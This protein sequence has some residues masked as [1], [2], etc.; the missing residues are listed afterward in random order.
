MGAHRY[1]LRYKTLGTTNWSSLGPIYHPANNTV[2][3]LLQQNTSY[4]W[5]IKTYH[6][7]STI[8]ASMWSLSDTFTTTSFV[9]ATFNPIISNT[10][11]TLEC[12]ATADLFLSI[13]QSNNEPDV[14]TSIITSGGGSFNINGLNFGDTIG[15][16]YTSTATQSLTGILTVGPSSQNY[17]IINSYDSTGSLIGFFVIE[18]SNGGIKVTSVSPNDGNNYTSGY[19]SEIYISNLFTNP[20]NAGPLDFYVDINSELNDQIYITETMQVWCDVTNIQ[21]SEGLPK[22]VFYTTDILGLSLIHI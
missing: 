3:P 10:L 16:A 19:V 11:S 17:A 21:E 22:E 13:T 14:G 18:N 5:Q 9:P 12:N 15:Y 4:E 1:K 8:L 20:P 7:T 6:D 2:I